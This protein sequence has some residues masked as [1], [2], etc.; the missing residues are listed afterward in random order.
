MQLDLPLQPQVRDALYNALNEAAHRVRNFLHRGE[1][2]AY[3]FENDG[4]N[5]VSC[6]FWATT[7]AD[8]VMES[9]IWPFGEPS[10]GHGQRPLFL[11]ELEL[12]ALLSEQPAKKRRF[13]EA[14]MPDL[15]A[16]LRTRDHLPNREKQREAVRKL[17]DFEPYHL[18]DRN[19]RI[20][21]K[22]VPRRSGRKRL[23]PEQ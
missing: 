11:K 2:K 13:P 1:L 20:A 15:V 9:G 22:Q 16:A 23:R 7:D 14:K 19:F 3:Y 18:T 4:H 6:D 12:D 17:R 5:S 8:E 10:H 21:E